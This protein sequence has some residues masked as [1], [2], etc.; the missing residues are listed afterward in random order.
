MKTR[1][2]QTLLQL[3]LLL[4]FST[5]ILQLSTLLAQSTAFSY[6]GRL[7]DGSSPANGNYDLSFTLFGVAS[8]GSALTLSHIVPTVVSDGL[9]TVTPDFG[10]LVFSGADRWLE[11]GARTNGG[12]TFTTLSPRQKVSA[13]PYAITASN[14]T[15]TLPST[16]L[17]G[18]LPSAQLSGTYTGAL[19]FNNAASSFSGNGGG[20]TGLSPTWRTG[21]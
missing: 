13:T 2:A 18:V 15:G 10:A 14:L 3:S 19:A 6:Q 5:P 7:T 8:G 21:G 17:S 12:G 4:L 20:L 9:F 1:P 16:Q 11:V